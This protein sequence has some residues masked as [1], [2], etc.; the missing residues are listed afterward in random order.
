MFFNK[1]ASRIDWKKIPATV[2]GFL[3]RYRR[4][5]LL[6]IFF[7]FIGYCVYLWYIYAFNP[8]WDEAK[9]LEYVNT[10]EKEV[11]FSRAKFDA[12]MND[13]RERKIEYQKSVDNVPDI[14]RLK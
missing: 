12:V 7:I 14:F 3:H 1:N 4:W 13:I 6:L 10:K 9:R 11:N 2:A 5:F 8:R